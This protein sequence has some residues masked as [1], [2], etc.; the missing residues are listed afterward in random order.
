MNERS[1]VNKVFYRVIEKK[2]GKGKVWNSNQSNDKPFKKNS[3]NVFNYQA[4]IR[5]IQAGRDA[6]IF[7][8]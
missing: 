3:R 5:A 8:N 7:V 1:R 2:K 6:E 4:T